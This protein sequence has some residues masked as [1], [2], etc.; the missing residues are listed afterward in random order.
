MGDS[1]AVPKSWLGGLRGCCGNS[2]VTTDSAL[3]MLKRRYA[4]GKIRK[5]EFEEKKEALI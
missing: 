1:Y 4:R 5:E 2:T 3:E